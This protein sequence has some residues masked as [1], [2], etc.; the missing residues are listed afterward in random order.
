MGTVVPFWRRVASR[1]VIVKL[2]ELGYLRPAKRYKEGVVEHAVE[3]LRHA[4]QRDGVISE[5]DLSRDLLQRT[6]HA[7]QARRHLAN[8]ASTWPRDQF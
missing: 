1:A 6:L 4:L 2:I 3:R 8:R 5:G 7:D